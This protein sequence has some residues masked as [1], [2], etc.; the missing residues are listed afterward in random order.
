MAY[1]QSTALEQVSYDEDAHTLRA[2]FRQSGKTYV[3]HDVP[4][5]TYDSLIFSDSLGAY[6]NSHIRDQFDFE[7]VEN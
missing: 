3:Y 2:R 4:P 6:F 1:V 7:E 5:D